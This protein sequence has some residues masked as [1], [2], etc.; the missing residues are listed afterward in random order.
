MYKTNRIWFLF[1]F[2]KKKGGKKCKS[3][4]QKIY[5]GGEKEGAK[6]MQHQDLFLQERQFLRFVFKKKRRE[7]TESKGQGNLRFK[8]LL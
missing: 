5:L 4:K 2:P 6:I 1:F 7:G 3:Q 8:K